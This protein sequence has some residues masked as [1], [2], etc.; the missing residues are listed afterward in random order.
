VRGRAAGT[1]GAAG[2][3]HIPNTGHHILMKSSPKGLGEILDGHE[4]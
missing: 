1:R 4:Y 3:A 2:V